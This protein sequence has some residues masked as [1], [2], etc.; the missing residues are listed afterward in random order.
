M[1]VNSGGPPFG[2]GHARQQIRGRFLLLLIP[3][4][5]TL[6]GCRSVLAF[7]NSRVMSKKQKAGCFLLVTDQL[8]QRSSIP[9]PSGDKMEI[10]EGSWGQGSNLSGGIES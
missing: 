5:P 2:G 8:R 6:V 1:E 4:E 10:S 3:Q 7:L 9:G